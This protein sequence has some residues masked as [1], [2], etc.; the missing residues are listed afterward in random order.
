MLTVTCSREALRQ[1]LLYPKAAAI[2]PSGQPPSDA[3]ELTV[4]FTLKRR[5]VEAKLILDNGDH[6]QPPNPDP[7]L[8]KAIAKAYA[9]NQKLM[10]GETKSIRA[11]AKEIGVTKRYICKL[12]PLAFL[13][14]DIVEAI[15]EGLHFP[16]LLPDRM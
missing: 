4:P 6:A 15:L 11:L 9:W 14:P 13:A 10:S 3:I 12:L 2:N 1:W 8:I 5:G 16:F 7:A